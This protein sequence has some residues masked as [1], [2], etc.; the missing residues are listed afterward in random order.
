MIPDSELIQGCL[1]GKQDVQK[2]FYQKYASTMFGIC[3]R[4]FQSREEA[5]DALQEGFIRVFTNLVSFRNEGSLEGWIKRIMVNTSLNLVRN[6]MKHQFH[7][8]VEEAEKDL[9]EDEDIIGNI[10]REEM[11]RLLQELP[12]GYRMVFNLYEI[13]GYSHKEIAEALSV[14]VS[15]SKTQL[16]KAR[17][18]LQKK[19]NHL[20]REAVIAPDSKE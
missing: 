14:T 11:L 12:N 19:F 3:L 15:T 8:D 17:K 2:L 13:E 1:D 20:N 10:S 9:S 7:L 16:L 4:Y 6:Q 5:E 18:L